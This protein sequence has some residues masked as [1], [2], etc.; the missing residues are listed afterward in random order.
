M[1]DAMSI[2][3]TLTRLT[4]TGLLS[5]AWGLSAWA[6]QAQF[7]RIV[8]F[9]TSLSDPGNY[10]ALHPINNTP[11]YT[12]LVDA[13]T[14]VPD[15]AY[16][17]GGHH[18]SNGA[19]WIEQLAR[20]LG[21]EGNVRGAFAGSGGATNYAVNGA[22]AHND[23]VNVDL[24]DQVGKFTNDF[25]GVAPGDALYVMEIGSNDVRDALQHY[26]AGD[27][28]GGNSILQ[29]ALTSIGG[30]LGNLYQMG[31]RRFFIWNVPD[32]SLTPAARRLDEASGTGTA[33]R[34]LARQLALVFNAQLALIVSNVAQLPGVDAKA[35]DAFH[36]SDEIVGNAP[37]FGLTDVV[38]ACIMPGVAPF[39]CQNA[40]QFL[41]WDGVHP[42][43]A[44]HAITA[45]QA[46]VVLGL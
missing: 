26:L 11:P 1:G 20:P 21:L 35:F 14:L 46:A 13:L 40:G 39:Y 25:A 15:A 43:K 44:G 36:A 38:D 16:A 4:L 24:R 34:D 10:F 41:F 17:V 12:A 37:A 28:V 19:T 30:E 33:I 6:G 2:I 42:T 29:Q 18:L 23:G 32:L 8:V 9:G 3:Q 5:L 45:N 7:D 31:A 22:R 27:T